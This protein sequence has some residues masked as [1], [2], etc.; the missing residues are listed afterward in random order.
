MT[1]EE[2]LAFFDAHPAI[3]NKPVTL[4]DVGLGYGHDH[5]RI[6][7]SQEEKRKEQLKR[8]LQKVHR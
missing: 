3:K 4:N 2:A 6:Q 5:C 8:A 7:P 1:V